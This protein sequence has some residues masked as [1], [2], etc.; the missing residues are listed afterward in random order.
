MINEIQKQEDKKINNDIPNKK[1][2]NK[3]VIVVENDDCFGGGSN[4]QD[5]FKNFMKIRQVSIKE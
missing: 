5:G 3:E 2:N 1:Q 4:L